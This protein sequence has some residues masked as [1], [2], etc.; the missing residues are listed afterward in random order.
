MRFRL[1][2]FGKA[3]KRWMVRST[4]GKLSFDRYGGG[5]K[6]IHDQ[7]HYHVCIARGPLQGVEIGKVAMDDRDF[8]DKVRAL[9]E[10]ARARCDA[11]NEM[12][13]R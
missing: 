5:W 13:G 1:G 3:P 9:R 4:G 6:W 8:D 11:L 10:Q 7:E 2:A 12:E